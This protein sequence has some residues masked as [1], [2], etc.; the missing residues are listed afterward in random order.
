MFPKVL[1]RLIIAAGLIFMM[2]GAYTARQAGILQ[3]RMHSID[4]VV[5]FRM[6][7]QV[8][9]GWDN[10]HTIPYGRELAEKGRELPNYF[11]RPLYKHPPLF[12][13]VNALSFRLFSR[14]GR[15]WPFYA[16]LVCG[17]LMIPLVYLIGSRVYNRSVGFAA[18]TIMALDP[19]GVMVS[20]KMW[21]D[22]M[23]GLLAVAALWGYVQA[24]T[25]RGAY[26]FILAGILSGLGAWTKYT[27]AVGTLVMIV[28]AV[29][30]DRRLFRN[31]YFIVSLCLPVV[32]LLPWLVWNIQVY[33]AGYT[34]LQ[35]HLLVDS[36]HFAILCRT[37]LILTILA[38]VTLYFYFR[39]R[40]QVSLDQEFMHKLRLVLGVT[41]VLA[42]FPAIIKSFSLT[43]LPDVG[44]SGAPFYG[45]SRGFYFE[46]LLEWNL[47]NFFAFLAFFLPRSD[48]RPGEKLLRT[49]F[50]VILALFTV[51]GAFQSRY[52]I[53]AVPLGIL[54]GSNV[55]YELWGKTAL[56]ESMP[57]RIA[58]R[59]AV[60][61]IACMI[62]VRMLYINHFV[63]YTN[64]MCYF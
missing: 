10:Y 19:I 7:M 63:S 59:S 62:L 41:T 32:M 29:I 61:V 30:F 47:V 11:F 60:V 31:R 27:G 9:K 40:S 15:M 46:R 16:S 37:L 51:W 6:A 36:P 4:E 13:A 8:R 24:I 33:G 23:L 54:I 22:S 44:W 3:T 14:H 25:G 52:I 17:L 26:F 53:A 64:D 39:Y 35:G 21:M 58:G 20:Q 28:Y 50:L 56:I 12:T 34:P 55:L 49:G 42:L 2:S 57:L 5:F 18:A 43:H 38:G 45:S 48:W 1:Q